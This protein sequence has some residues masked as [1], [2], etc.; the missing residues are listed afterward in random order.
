MVFQGLAGLAVF[1]L[2]AWS[3]SENRKQVSIKTIVFG[4]GAQLMIG[5]ILLK[6]AVFRQLFCC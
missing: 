5:L 3:M 4:V 6:V 2:L 1:I